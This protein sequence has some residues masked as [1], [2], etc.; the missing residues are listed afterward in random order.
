[1]GIVRRTAAARLAIVPNIGRARP[2]LGKDVRSF[3][4]RK[5]LLFYR[6]ITGGIELLRVIHGARNLRKIF[7]R[8]R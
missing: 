5:Y 7:G 3:P 8:R 2:E 6:P 4:V 1:M